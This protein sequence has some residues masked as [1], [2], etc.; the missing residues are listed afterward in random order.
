MGK[1]GPKVFEYCTQDQG[2][3]LLPYGPIQT[4]KKI[5]NVF[6]WF[7]FFLLCQEWS[8]YPIRLEDL[9]FWPKGMIL[10]N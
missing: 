5:I 7:C 2:H 4:G 1:K 9:G 10:D 6:L 8:N 3:S